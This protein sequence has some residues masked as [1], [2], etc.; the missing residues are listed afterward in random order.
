[1][2]RPI[3]TS[4]VILMTLTKELQSKLESCITQSSRFEVLANAYSGLVNAMNLLDKTKLPEV[5]EYIKNEKKWLR[6]EDTAKLRQYYEM[7]MELIPKYKK[8]KHITSL[9]KVI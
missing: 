8:E 3:K 5:A 1:M 4:G 9:D 7:A 2:L 6:E